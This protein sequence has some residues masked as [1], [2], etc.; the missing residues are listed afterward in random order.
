MPF[1]CCVRCQEKSLRVLHDAPRRPATLESLQPRNTWVSSAK[2]ILFAINCVF[3]GPSAAVRQA[4]T[5]QV[6]S[7]VVDTAAVAGKVAETG[8]ITQA[9]PTTASSMPNSI[10]PLSVSLKISHAIKAVV[11]GTKNIKLAT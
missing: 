10:R 6:H 11:G 8:L 9:T 5:H 4:R 7:V 2:Q 3:T 1:G